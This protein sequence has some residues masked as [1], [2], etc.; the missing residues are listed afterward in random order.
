MLVV[1]IIPDATRLGEIS[2]QP[3]SY[4]LSIQAETAGRSQK[5]FK[6]S[7]VSDPMQIAP[8]DRYLLSIIDYLSASLQ[9]LYI[10]TP[11]ERPARECESGEEDVL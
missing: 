5:K 3:S 9:R 11:E 6:V 2:P 8:K 7:S 4:A 1:R 10:M